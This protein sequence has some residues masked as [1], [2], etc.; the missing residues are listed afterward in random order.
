MKRNADGLLSTQAAGALVMLH[1]LCVHARV[2]AVYLSIE[3]VC[4]KD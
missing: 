1:A 2:R 3:I 4:G